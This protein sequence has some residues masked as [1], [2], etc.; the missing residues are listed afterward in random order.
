[1]KDVYRVWFCGT[2]VRVRA[3]WGQP[4]CPIQTEHLPGSWVWFNNLRVVDFP[5]GPRSA[6]AAIMRAIVEAAGEDPEVAEV[7][8]EI[9]AALEKIDP[10]I[11]PPLDLNVVRSPDYRDRAG[12]GAGPCLLC[13]NAIDVESGNIR[14]VRMD[15]GLGSIVDPA[16]PCQ[17]GGCFP[18]GLG[19][20]R[21]HRKTLKPYLLTG[22]PR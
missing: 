2:D 8:R 17:D 7:R 11:L 13:G 1:M 9:A 15:D 6:L 16:D 14:W 19:C 10:R 21:R 5:G 18:I 4:S 3:D 20:Y 12:A 22:G